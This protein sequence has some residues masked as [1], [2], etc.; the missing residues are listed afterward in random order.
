MHAPDASRH[1][2][3]PAYLR[4][5]VGA[6]DLASLAALIGVS[7]RSLRYYLSDQPGAPRAPYCVQYALEHLASGRG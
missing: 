5:L 4:T 2:P 3:D 1:N 6:W 7:V